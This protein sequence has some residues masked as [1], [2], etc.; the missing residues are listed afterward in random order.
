MPADGVAKIESLHS[1][2]KIAH[3]VAAAKLPVSEDLET[4]LLLLLQHPHNVFVFQRVKLIE[5]HARPPGSEQPW[6]PK[7]AADVIGA[8]LRRVSH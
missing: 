5:R 7:K 1:I 4:D 2:G 6:R 8:I 3:E